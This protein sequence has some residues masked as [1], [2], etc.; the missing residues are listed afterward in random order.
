MKAIV[1]FVTVIFIVL[2]GVGATWDAG[3]ED[4]PPET[5]V[6]ADED[7]EIMEI[8]A[9]AELLKDLEILEQIELIQDYDLLVEKKAEET[10]DAKDN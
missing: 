7:R 9:L 2:V 3:A 1:P 4:P 6:F 10:T 8:M 5:P